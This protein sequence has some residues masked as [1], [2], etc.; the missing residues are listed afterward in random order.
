VLAF[1]TFGLASISLFSSAA[2]VTMFGFLYQTKSP[3]EE[4]VAKPVSF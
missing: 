3:E 4:K 2:D 1:A